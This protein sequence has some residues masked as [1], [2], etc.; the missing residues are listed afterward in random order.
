M[1]YYKA[2]IFI[3]SFLL[4]NIFNFNI[5]KYYLNELIFK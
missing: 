4:N 2:T 1:N 5:L 3:N